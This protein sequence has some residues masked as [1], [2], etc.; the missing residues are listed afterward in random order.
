MKELCIKCHVDDK[1]MGHYRRVIFAD[2][3]CDTVAAVSAI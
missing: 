3:I 1:N 2:G